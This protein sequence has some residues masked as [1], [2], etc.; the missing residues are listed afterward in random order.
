LDALFSAAAMDDEE[1]SPTVGG[2]DSD[3]SSRGRT[4]V[5]ELLHALGYSLQANDKRIEGK[6]H[7]DRDAQFQTHRASDEGAATRW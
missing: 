3:G 7:P 6:Q 5:G 1:P 2:A 4:V